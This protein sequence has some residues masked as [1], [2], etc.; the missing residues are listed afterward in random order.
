MG[1]KIFE[2]IKQAWHIIFAFVPR[3]T[4]VRSFVGAVSALSAAA[5]P[6]G[7]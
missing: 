2:P 7:A 5:A 3:A 4:G 1:R 6:N